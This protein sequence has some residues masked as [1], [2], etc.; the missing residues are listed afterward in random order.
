MATLLPGAE[1]FFFPG[2]S[3]GALL[4]HGFTGAPREVRPLGEALAA[5]GLT[6]L[7]A[8]LAHHG[9][10]PEDMFRSGWHDWMASALDG[11]HLLRDQCATVFALGLSMGGLLALA[12]AARL[13]VAGVVTLSTPGRPLLDGM[14]WRARLAKPI[15][16]FIPFVDKG[17]PDPN[18]DPGHVAYPRYPVRA[19]AELRA[20]LA[21][22]DALLPALRVPALVIHS[23]G[24]ASVPMAN[25][26][27]IYQRLGSADKQLLRL[28]QSGH[29]L[30]EDVEREQVFAA[31]RTF[32]F[33][34]SHPA[35]Q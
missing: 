34:H 26:E 33:A 27:Y 15:S 16:R 9:T 20:L 3:T 17:P 1:P 32:V 31:A 24:D 30:T 12:L 8:R 25:G 14:T 13:P 18:A 29:I 6:C 5:A 35:S 28:R 19:V 21:A 2:G 23:Q 10:Q 11:Y 22:V 4:I 7:G